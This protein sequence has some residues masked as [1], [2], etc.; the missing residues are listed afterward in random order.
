MP[1]VLD[2][3]HLSWIGA[4]RACWRFD[5]G[6]NQTGEAECFFLQCLISGSIIMDVF[7]LSDMCFSCLWRSSLVLQEAALLA[8]LQW[9][10]GNLDTTRRTSA[11]YWT[12]MWQ[13]RWRLSPSCG[14]IR[15]DSSSILYVHII[16]SQKIRLITTIVSLSTLPWGC[17]L[18]QHRLQN[19]QDTDLRLLLSWWW[20]H[21]MTPGSPAVPWLNH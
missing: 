19:H 2:F 3:Q 15:T 16:T 9:I 11:C 12:N 4:G 21:T 17:C 13:M 5:K 18:W 10:L 1:N 8:Q 20:S 14:E 6:W 7:Q